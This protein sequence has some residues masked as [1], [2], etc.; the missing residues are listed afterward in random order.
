M[1]IFYG[2]FLIFLLA[3]LIVGILVVICLLIE[4]MFNIDMKKCIKNEIIKLKQIKNKKIS[5]MQTKRKVKKS[6]SLSI[7]AL[8]FE[9]E[10]IHN[11]IKEEN[12]KFRLNRYTK[13]FTSNDLYLIKL[14]E[15]FT[16]INQ[17]KTVKRNSIECLAC[18]YK[19][20]EDEYIWSDE[21][22]TSFSYNKFINDEYLNELKERMEK[23]DF[24]TFDG[25]E[26][27]AENQM[28]LMI[29]CD[30][31]YSEYENE[32]FWE[33]RRIILQMSFT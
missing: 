32:I 6:Q 25:R 24:K 29:L 30:H 5:K 18:L 31:K 11:I 22:D 2:L 10:E 14:H 8:K 27:T 1:R 23:E 21:T 20:I 7:E 19:A 17:I 16:K 4:I 9:Y 33:C 3:V 15:Y 26:V 12:E 13:Y 28:E